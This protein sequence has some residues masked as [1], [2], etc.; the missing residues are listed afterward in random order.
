MT[1]TPAYGRSYNKQADVL[2]DFNDGKDFLRHYML[3]PVK[4]INKEQVP[5]GTRV[6]FRYGR[7]GSKSFNHIVTK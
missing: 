4:P 6:T 7:D 1:L 5:A 2:R 3:D